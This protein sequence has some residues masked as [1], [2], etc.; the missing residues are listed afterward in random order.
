MHERVDGRHHER[1]GAAADLAAVRRAL[2]LQLHHRRD[3]LQEDHELGP[4]V[5]HPDDLLRD[6]ALEGLPLV[7]LLLLVLSITITSIKYYYY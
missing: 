5:P 4:L 3:A 2:V 6:G 7:L 1:L